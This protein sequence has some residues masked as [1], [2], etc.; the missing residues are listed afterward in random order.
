MKLP[1]VRACVR[2]SVCER[3]G[4]HLHASD[5]DREHCGEE[6]HLQE[7]VRHQPHHRKQT[8]LLQHK[9]QRSAHSGSWS[10]DDLKALREKVWSLI[11]L[12]TS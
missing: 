4:P 3:E 12:D 2:S 8:E 1:E 6:E 7:E 11:Y 10:S 9:T 5:V